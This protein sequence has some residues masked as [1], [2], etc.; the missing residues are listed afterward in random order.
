MVGSYYLCSLCLTTEL[1]HLTNDFHSSLDDKVQLYRW[2]EYNCDCCGCLLFMASG[3]FLPTT[4]ELCN[5]ARGAKARNVQLDPPT[6]NCPNATIKGCSVLA[7]PVDLVFVSRVSA[8]SVVCLKPALFPA[9]IWFL[10]EKC[11]T[12]SRHIWL[13][14]KESLVGLIAL[15]ALSMWWKIVGWVA[16]YRLNW[17]RQIYDVG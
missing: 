15:A 3:V 11:V 13:L 14:L 9:H 12:A 4:D 10:S 1:F 6:K 16:N 17:P 5:L 7:S 8:A 2:Q